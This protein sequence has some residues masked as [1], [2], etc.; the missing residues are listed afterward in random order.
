MH[1]HALVLTPTIWGVT[2]GVALLQGEPLKNT[3]VDHSSVSG[4]SRILA[5]CWQ[6]FP[7]R[8]RNVLT[9]KKLSLT[10]L[11]QRERLSFTINSL[12][13]NLFELFLEKKQKMYSS[14]HF[15]GKKMTAGLLSLYV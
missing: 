12:V 14:V 1:E 3:S 7:E 4:D 8:A 10:S 5:F 15:W 9:V 6:A 2:Q 13:V 11:S